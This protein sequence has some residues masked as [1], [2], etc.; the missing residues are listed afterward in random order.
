M[1]WTKAR[2]ADER[3][4]DRLETDIAAG[5]RALT[6]RRVP[7]VLRNVSVD[8]FMAEGCESLV[9]GMP[10]ML[11]LFDGR[12]FPARIVWKREGFCGGAFNTPISTATLATFV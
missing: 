4:A 8:G 3:G 2:V 11:D 6:G 7:V 9:P 5:L 12:T 10:I 1:T